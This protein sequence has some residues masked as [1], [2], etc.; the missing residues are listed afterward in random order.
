MTNVQP[1][2]PPYFWN[3]ADGQKKMAPDQCLD[4]QTRRRGVAWPQWDTAYRA[5]REI[6]Q[7]ECPSDNDDVGY[8]KR[9]PKH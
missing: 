2:K 8:V 4:C 9:H 6:A 1:T 5:S 3:F 7:D